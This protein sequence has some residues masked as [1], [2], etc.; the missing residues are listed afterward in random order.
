MAA[1]AKKS[2]GS[3]ASAPLAASLAGPAAMPELSYAAFAAATREQIEAAVK[4]NV[5]LNAGIE[6]IGREVMGYAR[7][8]LEAVSVTARGL[9]GART[10][11]DVVRLQADL[12][13]RNMDE[14]IAGSVKLSEL[15]CSMAAE[16]FA[17]WSGAEKLAPVPVGPIPVGARAAAAKAAEKPAAR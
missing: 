12:A 10:L 17:P 16:A 8:A 15:G 5:A 9:L 13:K 11:E 3:K 4:T 6:A 7:A 1:K 2:S 14:L